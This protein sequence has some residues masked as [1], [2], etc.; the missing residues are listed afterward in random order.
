MNRLSQRLQ[1][2]I[3]A[4]IEQGTFP[5]GDHPVAFGLMET[6]AFPSHGQPDPRAVMEGKGRR[7]DIP[8]FF[9]GNSGN[10]Q[11][12]LLHNRA[13]PAKLGIVT[14][15]LPL[16]PPAS[17]EQRAG[18]RDAFGRRMNH[19][20]QPPPDVTPLFPQRFPG[21]HVT[22]RGQGNQHRLA[23]IMSQAIPPKDQLFYLELSSC[24]QLHEVRM[25][26]QTAGYLS[27]LAK[28]VNS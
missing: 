16:T 1:N 5:R 2:S 3:Q 19:L 9:L 11:E 27:S 23:A 15:V 22:G 25:V 7:N 13:L 26:T 28:P 17:P 4:F 24:G 14:Q 6:Q 20:Q 21:N 8:Y 18:R 12:N 10:S